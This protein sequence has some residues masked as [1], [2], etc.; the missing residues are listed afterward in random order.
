MYYLVVNAALVCLY[1]CIFLVRGL[2]SC[3]CEVIVTLLYYPV[4]DKNLLVTRLLYPS[5]MHMH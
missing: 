5:R 4:R 1:I 3:T 2:C